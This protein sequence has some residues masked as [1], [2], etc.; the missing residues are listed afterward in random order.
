MPIR[1]DGESIGSF[2]PLLVSESSKHRGKLSDLAL[3]LATRSEGFRRSLPASIAAALADLVR[4]MNCYYSNLIEGHDIHPVDIERALNNDYSTEPE[5]RNLQLEARAH[6][7]VQ[8]WIDE[9]GLEGPPTS[10]EMIREMH[11]RFCALLP[12]ELLI[13]RDPATNEEM[14]VIAGALRERDV[15]VGRHIAISPG[16]VPR[17]LARMNDAYAKLGPGRC[18]PGL[19][20]GA[21]P[22]ALGAP[23]H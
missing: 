20:G 6:I 3:E 19:G 11:R 5:K 18:H 16:A 10:P 9:G 7:T 14:E 4:L 22:A 17:F 1:D 12:K 23:L 21:S 15:K 2:E 13:A 8:K